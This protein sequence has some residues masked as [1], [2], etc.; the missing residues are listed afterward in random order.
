MW[1]NQD[2]ESCQRHQ[3]VRRP[4]THPTKDRPIVCQDNQTRANDGFQAGINDKHAY[5]P[6]V[7]GK[8]AKTLAPAND[9]GKYGD[10]Y[11]T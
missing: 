6:R 10:P 2:P 9:V 5:M 8:K 7:C 4:I 1:V 3:Q 11:S